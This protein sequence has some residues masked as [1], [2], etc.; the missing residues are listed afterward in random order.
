MFV[1]CVTTAQP[2][3]ADVLVNRREGCMD[4]V[5]SFWR[6]QFAIFDRFEGCE[7]KPRE[8]KNPRMTRCCHPI[9]FWWSMVSFM[10]SLYRDSNVSSG[11]WTSV[12]GLL[13][14]DSMHAARLMPYG[15]ASLP[16]SVLIICWN[17]S[18][19]AGFPLHWRKC[20][21]FSGVSKQHVHKAMAGTFIFA[22]RSW[23]SPSGCLS[24]M[25]F[26]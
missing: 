1:E 9:C 20:H 10:A 26:M 22:S 14:C 15:W 16:V 23:L 2:D 21:W 3:G 13:R 11:S 25:N 7:A 17:A 19:R 5:L 18:S 4:A 6:I 24:C 8:C 12:V